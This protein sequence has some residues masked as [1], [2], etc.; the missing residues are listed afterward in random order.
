M[1]EPYANETHEARM[2]RIRETFQP[3]HEWADARAKHRLA[4][5]L[6]RHPWSV[7]GTKDSYKVW[8]RKTTEAIGKGR[9]I[10]TVAKDEPA[11]HAGGYFNVSSA[12]AQKN[13]SSWD[14][15]WPEGM[16]KS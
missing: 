2:N 10:Y 11:P 15:N 5:H 9:D 4:A 8:T 3:L 12:L 6:A 7:I 16:P 1:S 13:I 14:V